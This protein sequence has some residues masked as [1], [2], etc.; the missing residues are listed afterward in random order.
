MK[1]LYS[2]NENSYIASFK[3]YLT[4]TIYLLHIQISEQLGRISHY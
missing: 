1:N 2:K 4:K 3:I